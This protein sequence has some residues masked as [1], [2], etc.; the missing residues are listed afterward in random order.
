MFQ[1]MEDCRWG[2][3]W[4]TLVDGECLGPLPARSRS[5]GEVVPGAEGA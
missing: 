1:D 4:E 3:R 2:P 5:S